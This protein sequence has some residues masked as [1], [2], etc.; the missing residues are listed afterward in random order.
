MDGINDNAIDELRE[1]MKDKLTPDEKEE[2]DKLMKRVIEP[3]LFSAIQY[4]INSLELN[5]KLVKK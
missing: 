2:F 1:L 3:V 4:M 5:Y